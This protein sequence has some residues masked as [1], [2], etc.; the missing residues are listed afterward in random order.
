MSGTIPIFLRV[1]RDAME[2]VSIHQYRQRICCFS[3]LLFFGM[4]TSGSNVYVESG[5]LKG[6]FTEVGG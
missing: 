6:G 3:F 2:A 4:E 5:K 1:A